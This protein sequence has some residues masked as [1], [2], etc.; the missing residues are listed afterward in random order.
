[1]CFDCHYGVFITDR[2]S[3]VCGCLGEDER[4]RGK[5]RVR[6][7]DHWRDII[8]HWWLHSESQL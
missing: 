8:S 1:M 3:V 7:E 4:G 2:E 6:I 5:E